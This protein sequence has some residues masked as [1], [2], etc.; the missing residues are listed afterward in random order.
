MISQKHLEIINSWI[1]EVAESYVDVSQRSTFVTI[2]QRYL[3]TYI[4]DQE[5]GD[6]KRYQLYAL[7][8]IQVVIV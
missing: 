6:R 1:S 5:G 4:N 3:E 2:I 8:C 7:G